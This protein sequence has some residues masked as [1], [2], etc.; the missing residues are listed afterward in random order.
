MLLLQDKV[1]VVTGAA[2]SIGLASAKLFLEQGAFVVLADKNADALESIG[3]KMPQDRSAIFACDVT[4]SNDVKSLFDF[5]EN[6]FGPISVLFANAGNDGPLK[7]AVDYP[8]EIFDQIITTHVKGCFLSCKHV[9]PRMR[10]GG[11]IVI[12]SS[13]TGVKGVAGNVSY[14]AAKHALI[15]IMRGICKEV[16]P[17]GIR[18][19][20]VN[21][22]PIDNKFMRDAELSMSELLGRDA[23]A[24]FDEIIPMKRHGA[25]EEVAAAA[26]FLASDLS[27]YTTGSIL[28][29]DGGLTA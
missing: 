19:N 22:G 5:A 24:T 9:L 1:C 11:S 8:E 6:R 14:V 13:I 18:I 2:G 16:A 4:I 21:P 12:T 3:A 23:G 26:L 27:S 10:R 20:T 29:V 28:M 15:G 25:P 7:N 17:L